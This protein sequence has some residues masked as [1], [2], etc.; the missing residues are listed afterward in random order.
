MQQCARVPA[1]IRCSIP[2]AVPI[3]A[4]SAPNKE[5]CSLCD[6]VVVDGLLSCEFYYLGAQGRDQCRSNPHSVGTE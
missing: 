3:G 4:V 6:F 2:G 5:R 1:R